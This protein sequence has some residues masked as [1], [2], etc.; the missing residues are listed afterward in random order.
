MNN[1]KEKYLRI[2]DKAN[3]LAINKYGVKFDYLGWDI[4]R[5]IFL[6]AREII[7]KEV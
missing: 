5:I 2:L 7:N 6:K 1:M 3:E 4:Q